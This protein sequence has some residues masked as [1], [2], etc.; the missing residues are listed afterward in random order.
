[1]QE[2]QPSTQPNEMTRL[3]SSSE[4]YCA[5]ARPFFN[6][7]YE[8]INVPY[9]VLKNDIEIYRYELSNNPQMGPFIGLGIK[10]IDSSCYRYGV[11]TLNR[12]YENT[13]DNQ[14]ACIKISQYNGLYQTYFGSF[15]RNF[16]QILLDNTLESINSIIIQNKNELTTEINSNI[17]FTDQTNCTINFFTENE[18]ITNYNCNCEEIQVQ[19][20]SKIQESAESQPGPM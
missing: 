17:K 5:I 8:R 3:Y 18:T 14:G 2:E 10:N 13:E 19:T 20:E 12:N 1:M 4:Q 16:Q 11:N 6:T 7:I 9:P 15:L